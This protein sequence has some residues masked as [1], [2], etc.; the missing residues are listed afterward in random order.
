MPLFPPKHVAYSMGT[1]R[2]IR[3]PHTHLPRSALDSSSFNQYSSGGEDSKQNCLL[4]RLN[5]APITFVSSG[6]EYNF[7]KRTTISRRGG[8]SFE[9]STIKANQ[10]LSGPRPI[11]I[12]Y[13]RAEIN[14]QSLP[15]SA[16]TLTGTVTTHYPRN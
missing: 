14:C 8:S 13:P 7:I 3:P 2:F 16:I 6:P 10:G 4:A 5:S 11:I 15:C 1:P 12:L 9:N